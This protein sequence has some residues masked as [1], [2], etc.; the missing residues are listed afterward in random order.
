MSDPRQW[1]IRVIIGP[2]S[3]ESAESAAQWVAEGQGIPDGY[4]RAVSVEPF[5]DSSPFPSIREQVEKYLTENG[6]TL[7]HHPAGAIWR[8]PCSPTRFS[9]GNALDVQLTR[10]KEGTK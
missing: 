9:L 10:N 5:T 6:W 1:E 2:C 3:Q 7:D 4:G 8:S